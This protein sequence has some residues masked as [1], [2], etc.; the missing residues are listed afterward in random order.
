MKM[1]RRDASAKYMSRKF[2]RER[3]TYATIMG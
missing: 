2:E 1:H 3:E